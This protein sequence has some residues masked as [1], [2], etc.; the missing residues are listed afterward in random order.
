[1]RTVL[2]VL[3]VT[4]L[5]VLPASAQCSVGNAI[6]IEYQCTPNCSTIVGACQGSIGENC[7]QLASPRACCSHLILPYSSCNSSPSASPVLKANLQNPELRMLATNLDSSNGQ[8]SCSS[9]EFTRWLNKKL[10][11]AN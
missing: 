7:Q 11:I 3:A 1:M 9:V 6:V 2:L 10:R 5:A 8:G 4:V